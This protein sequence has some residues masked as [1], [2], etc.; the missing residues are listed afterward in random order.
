M[1]IVRIGR[2]TFQEGTRSELVG[3]DLILYEGEIA[4]EADT[5]LMKMGDGKTIYKEL[6]YM[7]RGPQGQKGDK[8]EKGDTG[9]SLTISG[10]VENESLLPKNPKDGEGYMVQGDL[11]IAKNGSFINVG[12]IKGPKGDT[13]PQGEQG[14]RGPQGIKGERGE[15]GPQGFKG[16]QGDRGPEGPKGDRGDV[17]PIGKTGPQGEQGPRGIQGS[18]GP[19]GPVGQTGP[20]GAKGDKGDP[21][22]FDEL[23]DEQKKDIANKVVI[24]DIAAAY[25]KKDDLIQSL[26]DKADKNDLNKKVDVVSGKSLSSND[27]TNDF[28]STLE[29][30]TMSNPPSTDFNSVSKQ[31]IYNGSFSS[32]CPNGSGKY[33]LIVCPTDSSTQHRTNYMF[34]IA[35]RDNSDS[36]PYFRQRRGS[37]NWGKWYKFSTNDYTDA[38]KRKVDVIP[39]NPK[40]SDTVTTINGK[41]GEIKKEDIESLGIG[42]LTKKEVAILTLKMDYS[43]Y[44]FGEAN[45]LN[46]ILNTV[47]NTNFDST[48]QNG[49]NI[50]RSADA[51]REL[52]SSD[53]AMRLVIKEEKFLVKLVNSSLSAQI[54]SEFG[55]AIKLIAN[56]KN[57]MRICVGSDAFLNAL[58]SKRKR[59]KGNNFINGEFII[60]DISTDNAWRDTSFGY[61]LLK[62][63]G[64]ES[65]NDYR[66]KYAF[67]KAY[68]SYA[69]YIKNDSDSD[70]W[71]DYYDI[72][73][74]N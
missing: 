22:T 56:S 38:D 55:N 2:F 12:R 18:T 19:Q 58:Y 57:G 45:N 16:D 48:I 20:K 62:N 13:G 54:L 31:G 59:L 26:S 27:F 65:W 33:T 1:K 17:G 11:Y 51:L 34:Q 23:T 30:L 70:D 50:L 4:L 24:D 43:N 40:Y 68:P 74:P 7:N 63:F 21:L 6:P 42:G 14:P 60:L 47:F 28:K 41:S 73:N 52:F 67:V 3:S 15:I 53:D 29:E 64:N 71:I 25:V 66:R 37:S 9:T 49:D 46:E 69:T 72:D 39:S 5:Q 32:N 8:G 61:A 10:T 35:I 44:L 36:T